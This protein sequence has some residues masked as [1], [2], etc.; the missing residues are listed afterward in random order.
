M[1]ISTEIDGTHL[2]P[3]AAHPDV[4]LS[5]NIHNNGTKDVVIRFMSGQMFDIRLY[6][7]KHTEI[8]CWSDEQMFM[9][10]LQEVRISPGQSQQFSGELPLSHRDGKP[11]EIGS[12][13]LEFEVTGS[14]APEASAFTPTRIKTLTPIYIDQRM[15]AFSS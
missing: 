8:R 14:M 6:D 5:L 12:Y 7:A 4:K 13:F 10:M 2:V 1:I 9:Q 15:T 3:D 11:L